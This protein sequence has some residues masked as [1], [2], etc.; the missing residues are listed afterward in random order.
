MVFKIAAFD[1]IYSQFTGGYNIMY[2]FLLHFIVFMSSACGTGAA[3]SRV[4]FLPPNGVNRFKRAEHFQL[5][6]LGHRI[7]MH[8]K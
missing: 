8:K 7:M 6:K 2:T 4:C 5:S 1:E 3:P